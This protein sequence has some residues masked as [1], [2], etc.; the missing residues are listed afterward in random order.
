MI[1]GRRKIKVEIDFSNS[2]P[3]MEEMFLDLNTFA[4][5]HNISLEVNKDI[6]FKLFEYL[7]RGIHPV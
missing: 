3:F 1:N 7:T 4:E 6:S 5:K 2:Q